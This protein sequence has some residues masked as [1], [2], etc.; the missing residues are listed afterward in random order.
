MSG[1]KATAEAIPDAELVIIEGMGHD[2]PPA[3][4]A[5]IAGAIERTVRRGEACLRAR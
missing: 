3:A 4:W 5:Q 1:A 2:L